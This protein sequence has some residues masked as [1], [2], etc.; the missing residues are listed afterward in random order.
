MRLLKAILLAPLLYLAAGAIGGAVPANPGWR[1][2]GK[3]VTI[4]V[5]SNGWHSGLVLPA[6]TREADWTGL[7]RARHLSDPARAGRY[8][9]F[10]WG[11]RDFYLNTPSW[12]ELSPRTLIRAALG[13]PDTLVHVDHLDWPP[14]TARPVRLSPREY[15]RLVHAIR[16]SFAPGPPIAGYGPADIFYPAH[17]RYDL[18]RTCN[19]WTGRMLAEAGV[20][21]GRWT[22]FSATVM[23]W[24]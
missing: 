3:G 5:A 10:G 19:W 23:Q 8:L 1:E 9:W 21:V 20:R 11:E 15:R 17:G 6:R 22:P 13:S 7:V 4:W 2:A 12:A 14:E 24:F 18:I 16:A